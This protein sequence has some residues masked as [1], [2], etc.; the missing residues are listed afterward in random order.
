MAAYVLASRGLR[1]ALLEKGRNPYPTLGKD[2]LQGSLF[3]N[4]EV[5]DLLSSFGV[6]DSFDDDQ[7]MGRE[8]K[9]MVGVEPTPPPPDPEKT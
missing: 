2:K 1:V 3:G 9:A 4:D 8:L 7:S 6:S 5:D